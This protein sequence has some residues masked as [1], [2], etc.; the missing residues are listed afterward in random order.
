MLFACGAAYRILRFQSLLETSVAPSPSVLNMAEEIAGRLDLKQTPE[1]RLLPMCVSPLVWSLGA[2]PRVF[3]PATLFDRLDRAAQEAILAHELAHVRRRDHWVRLLEAAITVLFW[4]HPV[5]WWAARQ[6]Q[7]FEDQCCDAMVVDLAPDAAKSYATA[8]LDTLDFLCEGSTAAPLGA[9]AAKSSFSLT[10][11]IAMLKNRSWTARL[12]VG[13][14]MLLVTAAAIPMAIAFGQ[15]PPD[16]TEKAQVAVARRVVNKLVRDFPEK[17]DLSTPESAAAMYHRV[18]ASPD[19]KSW[20]DLSAWAYSARD[21]VDIKR[22]MESH[23][24]ERAWTD[25]AY[26]NAEIIEVLTY[27]EGLSQVTS[28]LDLKGPGREPY[29]ARIFVKIGDVWKNFGEDRLASPEK[30]REHF[31]RIKDSLW[32]SYLQVLDGV[33]KG[34]PVRLEADDLS[35]SRPKRSAPIA[36]GEPLGISVEKADLMGRVEWAMMHGGRDITARKTIEWGDVEKDADG[37]RRIRYK[38]YATI[39]DRD[40]H[41]VNRVFTFDA[42]GNILDME[43]VEGFPQKKVEKPVNASTQEGMKELVEDFFTKNFRDVTARECL[44]WGEVTKDKDGNSS[45][46]HRY[47]AKIWDKDTKIINQVFT[48]DPKGKFVSVKDVEELPEKH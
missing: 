13:R 32:A 20:L 39:W 34:K 6:L 2:G 37:N 10:R 3:L 11:R 33:A 16:A 28:K 9:T 8:L 17:A 30:A 36:P 45:I 35:S 31:N 26:R 41:I 19:P 44:E 42:K 21:V 7:E 47:R 18:I 46:R 14:F 1:I 43:D 22:K 40:V 27:R 23:R 38:F 15:K 48:F 5:V 4:W 12:T 29:S 24:D 25:E